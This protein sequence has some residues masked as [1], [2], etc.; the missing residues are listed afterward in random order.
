MTARPPLTD[1]H[2]AL[3]LRLFE[4]L[5]RGGAPWLD[6]VMCALS[7]R[8]F[9]IGFGVALCVALL[10]AMRRGALRPV[11]A[12]GAAIVIADLLGSQAIRPLLGRMRPCYALPRGTFRWLLPAANG[13]SLPSLHA[14][15]M[16]ALA[17]VVTLARP[18]LAPVAYAAAV[19]VS[20]S[21][22]YVGV[23]W[24]TDV[25]A[26]MVWGTV[27]AAIA[28]AATARLARPRPAQGP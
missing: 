7:S 13:P 3:D 8:L 28:W 27:A 12:L 14:S 23:H 19:A 20:L 26:G 15:N 18:R 1:V 24:P 22:V 17:L 21:R 5:N 11:V 9:G 25:L 16:F 2:S 4:L 10:V 6:A